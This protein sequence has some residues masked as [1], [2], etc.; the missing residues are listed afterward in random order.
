MMSAENYA[1][2]KAIGNERADI[3]PTMNSMREVEPSCNFKL[4]ERLRVVESVGNEP[5]SMDDEE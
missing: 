4:V 2:L 5:V 3:W 1:A